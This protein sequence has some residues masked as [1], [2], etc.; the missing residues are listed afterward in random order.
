MI[1]AIT[2]AKGGTG[3]STTAGALAAGLARR[4]NRVLLVDADSQANASFGAG[5][6]DPVYTLAE[7]LRGR[8][9]AA[10]AIVP[11]VNGF[12]LLPAGAA[13]D[14]V[15]LAG[16]DIK[17]FVSAIQSVAAG[18]DAVIIDT[19]PNMGYLTAAA[20]TTAD[21][22]IIPTEAEPYATTGLLHFVQLINSAGAANKL[23][24]ILITAFNRQRKGHMST[25]EAIRGLFGDKVFKTVIRINTA[26][27]DAQ[28]WQKSI[29]DY[30]PSS[31]GAADYAAFTQEVAERIGAR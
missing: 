23:A 12:D 19:K 5:V 3:K 20:V 21:R 16:L 30:A 27:T 28:S 2:N 9:S 22:L 11:T 31:N 17:V 6:A 29:Y 15:E 26:I 7:V 8:V 4:G 13:L 14:A 25:E 10:D 1:V 18:Y 24:G